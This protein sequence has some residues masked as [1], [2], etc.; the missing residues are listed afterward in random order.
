MCGCRDLNV[1]DQKRRSSK[2]V[3]SVEF[4]SEVF[5]WPSS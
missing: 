3:E 1:R 2:K 5:G 4:V